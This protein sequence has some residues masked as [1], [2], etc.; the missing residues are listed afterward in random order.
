MQVV[1]MVTSVAFAGEP[2]AT[3]DVDVVVTSET[4]RIQWRLPVAQAPKV[5][6]VIDIEANVRP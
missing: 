6:A 4:G 1:G 2:S 5:G 3:G